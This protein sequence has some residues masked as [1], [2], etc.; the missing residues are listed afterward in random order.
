MFYAISLLPYYTF[1]TFF[2]LLQDL[3]IKKSEKIEKK[4]L[5]IPIWKNNLL[6]LTNKSDIVFVKLTVVYFNE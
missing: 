1:Y 2:S 5:L 6:K 4:R 3:L